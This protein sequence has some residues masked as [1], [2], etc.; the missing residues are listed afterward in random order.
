MWVNKKGTEKYDYS[1]M[2][3]GQI[4]NLAVY[5]SAVLERVFTLLVSLE[6]FLEALFL[7]MIPFD[8]ALLMVFIAFRRAPAA[9][10]LSPVF[11]DASTFL[12]TPR[13]LVRS[14]LLRSFLFSDCLSLLIADRFFLGA[15]FAAKLK[16]LL[17]KSLI[18]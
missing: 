8:F 13:I 7:W 2:P 16:F 11:T 15:D 17:L 18:L 4:M 14:I 10:S 9:V 3:A 6:I 5:A 1:S 12:T